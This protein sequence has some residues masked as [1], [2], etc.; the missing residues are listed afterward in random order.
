MPANNYDTAI[1]GVTFEEVYNRL[2]DAKVI[3]NY[4]A[5]ARILECNRS[6]ITPALQKNHIPT[7]WKKRFEDKGFNFDWIAYG[8]GEKYNS[9][10]ISLYN[11]IVL[12]NH[13]SK[14]TND[15]RPIISDISP[16]VPL[17]KSFMERNKLIPKKTGY[18]VYNNKGSISYLKKGDIVIVDFSNKTLEA[19]KTFLIRTH[20]GEWDIYKIEKKSPTRSFFQN[21]EQ[22]RLN[23]VFNSEAIV[24]G[25]CVSGFINL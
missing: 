17:T 6:N 24:C 3:K 8:I 13:I 2:I 21:K 4:S 18:W 15:G 10:H 5:L 20:N 16:R 14:I 25:Q 7:G 23:Y 1:P 22:S 9:F 12:I 11:D 19:N